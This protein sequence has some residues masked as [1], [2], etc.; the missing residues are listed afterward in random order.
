[1]P[2]ERTKGVVVTRTAFGNLLVGPTAEE[3]RERDFPTTDGR[4]IAEPAASRSPDDPALASEPVT[5]SY[6]GLRPATQFKDYQI[7]A[8]PTERWITVAG[9]RSTGLTSAL[10]IGAY[11]AGLYAQHFGALEKIAEPQWIS[12]PNLTEGARAFLDV[13]RSI[14]DHLRIVRWSQGRRSRRR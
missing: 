3:Q 8:L 12:M 7:E 13:P 6:A 4:I 5:A 14:R 9:I 2:N 10:G 11:V 1:M